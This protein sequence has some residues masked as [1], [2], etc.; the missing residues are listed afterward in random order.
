[1]AV[2]GVCA[3]VL[4]LPLKKFKT[5]LIDFTEIHTISH[6]TKVFS[7]RMFQVPLQLSDVSVE[8]RLDSFY[9]TEMR[10]ESRKE[11]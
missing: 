7:T 5:K 6:F 1:M 10:K 9:C 3:A 4:P 8:D 11:P 2:C